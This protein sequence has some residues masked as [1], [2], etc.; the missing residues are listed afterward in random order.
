MY[1]FVLST[2]KSTKNAMHLHVLK[3]LPKYSIIFKTFNI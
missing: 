1:A 3:Q 2:S